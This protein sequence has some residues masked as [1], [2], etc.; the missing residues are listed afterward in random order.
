[1]SSS[2]SSSSS[3]APTTNHLRDDNTTDVFAP[4]TVVAFSSQSPS[5]S[6]SPVT[7]SEQYISEQ[8]KKSGVK[9]LDGSDEAEED[10]SFET[11]A[12]RSLIDGGECLLDTSDTDNSL[13]IG[14]TS[15]DER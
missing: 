6:S 5:L 9:T 10:I 13:L 7:I 14:D 8:R 11:I 15:D 3:R 12:G 4:P 1:M 2:S